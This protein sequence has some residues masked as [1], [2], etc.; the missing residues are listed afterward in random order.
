MDLIYSP[1]DATILGARSKSRSR[2]RPNKIK[3]GSRVLAPLYYNSHLI[4]QEKKRKLDKENE[5]DQ[6]KPK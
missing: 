2:S 1:T 6:C 5:Q 4:L 3:I